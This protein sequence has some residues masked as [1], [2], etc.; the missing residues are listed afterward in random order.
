MKLTYI[1]EEEERE[2]I[3][4]RIGKFSILLESFEDLFPSYGYIIRAFWD[5]RSGAGLL[6]DDWVG[7]ISVAVLWIKVVQNVHHQIPRTTQ[8]AF[9]NRMVYWSTNALVA[10][11]MR[12]ERLRRRVKR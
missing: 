3:Q 5:S 4:K 10:S 9:V 6:V 12:I 7:I 1:S 11:G 8:Y 2:Q